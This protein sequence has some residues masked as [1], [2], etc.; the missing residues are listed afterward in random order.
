VA[1]TVVLSVIAHGLTAGPLAAR[2]GRRMRVLAADAPEREDAAEPQHPRVSWAG[3]PP[4][5]PAA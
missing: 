1:W 4:K 5:G 2:Y 3:E